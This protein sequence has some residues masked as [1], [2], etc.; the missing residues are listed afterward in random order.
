MSKLQVVEGVTFVYQPPPRSKVPHAASILIEHDSSTTSSK[1]PPLS[2][3]DHPL[4]AF[5]SS[6][7]PLGAHTPVYDTTLPTPAQ[8]FQGN[9]AL[10]RAVSSPVRAPHTSRATTPT[11]SLERT[12]TCPHA[13]TTTKPLSFFCYTPKTDRSVGVPPMRTSPTTVPVPLT[14]PFG[15]VADETSLSTAFGMATPLQR[16]LQVA[17]CNAAEQQPYGMLPA[18][19]AAYGGGDG[20]APPLFGGH[21]SLPL[22]PVPVN[23][24]FTTPELSH[25]LQGLQFGGWGAVGEEHA[26]NALQF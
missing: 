21:P 5:T 15:G 4:S 26:G 16:A 6:M 18:F 14:T 24:P 20:M 22:A 1:S 2:V 25:E 3:V 11:P 23:L 12:A 19:D 17:L 7:P 9:P 8:V 10:L 13:A